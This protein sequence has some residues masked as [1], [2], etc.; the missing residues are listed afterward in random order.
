[1]SMARQLVW[2][3]RLDLVV[4]HGRLQWEGV[5]EDDG[6]AGTTIRH[7]DRLT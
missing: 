3:G 4:P 1:M 6:V 5:E 7:V 2:A